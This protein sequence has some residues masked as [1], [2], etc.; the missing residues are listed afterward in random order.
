[1]KPADISQL[2]RSVPPNLPLYGYTI[3][4]EDYT[5]GDLDSLWTQRYI[6]AVDDPAFGYEFVSAFAKHDEFLPTTCACTCTN[7]LIEAW[8]DLAGR[9]KINLLQRNR[10]RL[11]RQFGQA[12]LVQLPNGQYE[13]IG[14]SDADRAAA[15]EWTSLFAHEIVFSHFH[16]EAPLPEPTRWDWFSFPIAGRR[17]VA[18]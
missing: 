16:R 14:G 1:M 9:L 10:T 12:K 15:F 8:W 6:Q 17:A 5:T 3:Q 2:V 4:R 13:L 7:S 18:A 11:V